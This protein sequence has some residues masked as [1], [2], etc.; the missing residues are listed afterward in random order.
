[1]PIDDADRAA[2]VLDQRRAA[3]YPVTGVAVQ[4]T[5]YVP[6]GG[7]MD[8][9]ADQASDILLPRLG[10]RIIPRRSCKG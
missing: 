8:M 1:M 3:F 9:A 2:S 7:M 4:N 6:D 5:V 10:A